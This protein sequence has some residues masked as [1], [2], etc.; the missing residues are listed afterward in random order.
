MDL[1]PDLKMNIGCCTK[2]P[3]LNTR[4]FNIFFTFEFEIHHTTL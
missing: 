3:L 4:Y 2:Y 1:I